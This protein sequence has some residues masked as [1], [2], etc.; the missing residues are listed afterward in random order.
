[1]RAVVIILAL[2]AGLKVWTHESLFRAATEDALLRAYAARAV[3]SC[4]KYVQTD[5]RGQ[6]LTA[7][8]IDWSSYRSAKLMIG[9]ASVPVSIWQID[10][11]LWDKRYKNPYILL[12]V[13]HAHWPATCAYDIVA[14]RARLA[15]S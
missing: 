6:P 4:Q 10:H 13:D 9:D 2:L 11:E 14:G 7:T 5:P 15:R 3:K 12:K 8:P 1:M